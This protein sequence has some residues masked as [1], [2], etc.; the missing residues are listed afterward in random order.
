MPKT[1][2]WGLII[3]KTLKNK[4]LNYITLIDEVK[5]VYEEDYGDI[6]TRPDKK[7][8]E[9]L[10]KLLKKDEIEIFD[11][12][13]N[14]HKNPNR[15]QAFITDGIKFRLSG[16]KA[17]EIRRLIKI[18]D[19]TDKEKQ[20]KAFKKLRRIFLKK[21]E[22][23]LDHIQ[24]DWNYL[25][26]Q[27]TIEEFSDDLIISEIVESEIDKEMPNY[28]ADPDFVEDIVK[29][30]KKNNFKIPEDLRMKYSE[31]ELWT[32]KNYSKKVPKKENI[33]KEKFLENMGFI[34]PNYLNTYQIYDSF[35]KTL[36]YVKQNK[37]KSFIEG[38]FILALSSFE[39]SDKWF[40]ELITEVN[41][42][43]NLSKPSL[44]QK[45]FGYELIK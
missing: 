31:Y 6:G 21:Y 16:V 18:V 5:K 38:K 23:Y 25:L 1:S 34:K 8:D 10:I 36:T 27:V 33:T 11:Y 17:N 13:I 44:Y 43:L 40:K 2:Q 29:K 37:N 22:E 3:K 28:V 15:I 12:D 42:C 14:V 7:F 24:R 41:S 9:S 4:S 20:N 39:D 30:Y 32:L 45:I 19:D 35:E 26:T